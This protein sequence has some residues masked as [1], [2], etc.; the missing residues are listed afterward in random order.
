MHVKIIHWVTCLRAPG[1]FV[2]CGCRSITAA[3]LSDVS[4]WQKHLLY[5]NN[6][7]AT[8]WWHFNLGKAWSIEK[9]NSSMSQLVVGWTGMD[10]CIVVC[11]YFCLGWYILIDRG[12]NEENAIVVAPCI[13][14]P[15]WHEKKGDEDLLLMCVAAIFNLCNI[16]I[17]LFGK[18][19]PALPSQL[20]FH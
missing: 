9:K 15:E 16:F 10:T 6:V 4:A 2:A 14:H 19:L 3:V 20:E 18:R 13:C 8:E 11:I 12:A 1:G 7:F 17:C 5:Y